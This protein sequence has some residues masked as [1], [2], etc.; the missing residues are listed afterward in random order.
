MPYPET[1]LKAARQRHSPTASLT[2]VRS[3]RPVNLAFSRAASL[4]FLRLFC[5]P[6]V[7]LSDLK[8]MQLH[9]AVEHLIGQTPAPLCLFAIVSRFGLHGRGDSRTIAVFRRVGGG[10]MIQQKLNFYRLHFINPKTGLIGHTYEFLVDD[11]EAAIRFTDVWAEDA[12]MELRSRS[13][14]VKRWSRS[15][16]GD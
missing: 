6:V 16:K 2:S 15:S 13:G 12:P 3:D 1:R 7:F 10:K 14:L 11:D 8:Q 4:S 5:E 9:C